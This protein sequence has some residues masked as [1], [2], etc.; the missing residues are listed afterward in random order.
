MKFVTETL[1]TEG[2]SLF[3]GCSWGGTFDVSQAFHHVDMDPSAFT[4]L[5]FEW[6]CH[7]YYFCVLPFGLACAPRIFTRIMR[8]T[9]ASLRWH[10]CRLMIFNDDLPFAQTSK[11]AAL[12]QAA[13]MFRMLQEFGWL[14]NQTNASGCFSPS[15][16][17]MP[18]ARASTCA[19]S[20]FL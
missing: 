20:V 4:Y 6:A 13:T 11:A 2:R 12:E 1:Q 18:S 5:R 17:F 14:L 10:G 3:G 9:V 16:S 15:K 8:T 7:C 19:F